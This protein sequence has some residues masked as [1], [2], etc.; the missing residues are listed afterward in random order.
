MRNKKAYIAFIV[1][2][3]K[4]EPAVI[5][6]MGRVFFHNSQIKEIILPA[7]QN[8]YMLWKIMSKDHF[9]TDIIEVLRESDI[10][11]SQVLGDL[12]R[13]DFSEVYLFF[14]YDGHQNNLNEEDK[15]TDV[16]EQML[17]SFDN[18][19]ENGKLY[20]SYP[21]IE[22]LRDFKEGECTS[23]TSCFWNIKEIERYKNESSGNMMSSRLGQYEFLQWESI[24]NTFAMRVSCLYEKEKV[25]SFEE[26]QKEIKPC[27][28][29]AKQQK[30]IADG[31][32]F[33]LSSLPEFLLDYHKIEF[34]YRF[35][36]NRFLVSNDCVK[37]R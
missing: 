26:Y 31:Q 23:Y 9:N 35:V 14:D 3:K 4:R 8:I 22:A 7:D 32:I 2:G 30:Y 29:Y 20:I 16:I 18:E 13:D 24:L 28:I 33:V 36:K 5:E 25:I 21:M 15:E 10:A 27:D 37:R 1:E 17:S 12:S 6:N 11:V 34:W 19:T